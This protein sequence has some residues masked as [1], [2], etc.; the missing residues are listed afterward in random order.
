MDVRQRLCTYC[1]TPLNEE[2]R[3]AFSWVGTKDALACSWQCYVSLQDFAL[4]MGHRL[5]EQRS[6]VRN[7]PYTK[8][9]R[10]HEKSHVIYTPVEPP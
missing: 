2:H 1:N 6:S 10:G 9:L 7:L 5:K 3:R 8:V 4:L